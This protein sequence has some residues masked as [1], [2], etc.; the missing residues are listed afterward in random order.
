MY[1]QHGGGVTQ[2]LES[3]ESSTRVDAN[4]NILRAC[5]NLRQALFHIL[6]A[7]PGGSCMIDINE[8]INKK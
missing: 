7:I 1:L 6:I 2:D 4:P 3:R 8:S 5:R